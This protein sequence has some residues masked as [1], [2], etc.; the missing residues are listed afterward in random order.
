MGVLLIFILFMCQVNGNLHFSCD[1][2]G[3]RIFH[4]SSFS[5]I[6]AKLLDKI[7]KKCYTE[8]VTRILY[9]VEKFLFK[10]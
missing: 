2:F 6:Y 8:Y 5:F 1:N 4:K 10:E 9:G 3:Y 7:K